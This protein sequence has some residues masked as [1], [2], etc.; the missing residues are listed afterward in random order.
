MTAAAPASAP[1]FV[2]DDDPTGAQGQADVPLLLCWRAGLL[3]AALRDDPPALHLLTNSRAL[4]EDAAYAVVREAVEAADAAASQP[5]L[6]LRGDS[7]LRAH[8]LP[9]YAGVRDALYP[10]AAPPLLLVPALPA[11]GRITRGGRHWL[12]RGGRRIPLEETEFA[13][14]GEFSYDTSRLLDWADERSDGFFAAQSGIEVG[15]AEIRSEGGADRVT[16]A[17]LEAARGPRPAVV[18][19][20]AETQADLETIADG[21][22][23]AWLQAPMIVVRCAP[24]F[25]SVLSGAGAAEEVALP[26]V[27]RG[28]LVVVGSHVSM[29]SAQLAALDSR[30][31]GALVELDPEA[32]AGP[33]ATGAVAAAVERARPLLE[34]TRLAVVATSRAI[35]PKAAGPEAGMR[36]ARGLA[37]VVDELRDASDVLLSK[38]GITSAV[39]VRDGLHAERAQIVGPVATGV[40]L[41]LA[42]EDGDHVRPVLVFPGN[43]GDVDTLAELVDRLL[44]E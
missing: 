42:H 44:E 19:P 40:S 35:E 14:D 6:V 39:N 15:L 10:G 7:T 9:E 24:A 2:V 41:W 23:R 21:L 18:V 12:V 33:G 43:V 11:A 31:P 36:V 30:H 29:S 26:S 37:R 17:L 28:L 1:L 4:D 3:E 38:G 22:R 8:L 27:E 25:A 16:E 32:L 20:D 5:R 34:Q 13:S